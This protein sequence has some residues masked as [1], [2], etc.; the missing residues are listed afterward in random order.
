MAASASGMTGQE[1][2]IYKKV[3]KPVLLT[4]LLMGILNYLL[5]MVFRINIGGL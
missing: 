3:I 5:L 4:A 1:P 2:E